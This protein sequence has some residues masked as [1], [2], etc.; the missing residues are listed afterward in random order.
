MGIKLKLGARIRLG[1]GCLLALVILI[2]LLV[3]IEMN[4]INQK[5]ILIRQYNA[6]MKMCTTMQKSILNV[7]KAMRGILLDSDMNENKL[8]MNNAF[9]DYDQAYQE[10][11]QVF[12]TGAAR[13]MLEEIKRVD[14]SV[15]S[16][17]IHLL[18]LY[19]TA[20]DS[21]N[22]VKIKTMFFDQVG[23][24]VKE[25]TI[26][27][28]TLQNLGEKLTETVIEEAENTYHLTLAILILSGGIAL[29]LGMLLAFLITRSITKPMNSI[30]S[31]IGEGAGQVAAASGELSVSA[32]LLSQGSTEQAAAIEETSSTLQQ[33]A[34]M[35]EQNSTNTIQAAQ[36]SVEAKKTADKGNI[37][38]QQMMESIQEI[39]DS[40]DQ[41]AKII[42]V[43]DDIAFQ[44]NIL[45]LNAAIEAARAGEAGMGFAVVAE[46]VR[47]LAGKSAEAA[48]NTAA[49]ID[50]NIQ[51][52]N[53][54]VAVAGKVSEA[55]AEITIQ[56]QK[57]SK[58]MDEIA[59]SSREQAQGVVQVN[60]AMTQ[61]ETVTQ[62]NAANAEERASAA[63]ELSAQAENM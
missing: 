26:Q 11:T 1:F 14:D 52:A 42:K 45:A 9:S 31:R 30:T 23:A 53:K 27:L 43:I 13:K 41:I 58:L 49:I 63:A 29:A 61:M 36:L 28:D 38:M 54:G 32:Q 10:A 21:Q 2:V 56:S 62:Q 22:D 20:H 17:A 12:K 46:E 24:P 34:S 59:A 48:K 25:W 7:S 15:R 5:I 6:D 40:S 18:D 60:K 4:F 33:S 47:T 44:T 50:S 3:M 55:L 35:M 19:M 39:K 8:A 16:T 57:V 37:E 51:L